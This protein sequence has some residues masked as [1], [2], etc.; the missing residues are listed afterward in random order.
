VAQTSLF[1]LPADVTEKVLQL[2]AENTISVDNPVL[3]T[4]CLLWTGHLHND[5]KYAYCG[6]RNLGRYRNFFGHRLAYLVYHGSIAPGLH[7]RHRCTNKHCLAKDHLISGTHAD[8][9]HDRRAAGHYNKLG[10]NLTPDQVTAGLE[11]S[12]DKKMS[13]RKIAGM[14]GVHPSTVSL[15]L[16]GLTFHNIYR[17]FAC[18]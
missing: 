10:K 13:A 15:F 8:N 6:Y 17:K 14:L 18:A 7:V 2:I 5:T 16:R 12:R 11:M 1:R 4:P 9:M 3:G